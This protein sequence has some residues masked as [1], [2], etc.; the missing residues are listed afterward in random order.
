MP[1]NQFGDLEGPSERLERALGQGLMETADQA[2]VGQ[3]GFLVRTASELEYHLGS[4][5][6][7][8]RHESAVLEEALELDESIVGCAREATER[9]V[10][11]QPASHPPRF[12]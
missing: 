10:A 8:L 11:D 9:R 7:L 12:T 2:R 6:D 4:A 5:S 3:G 1:G